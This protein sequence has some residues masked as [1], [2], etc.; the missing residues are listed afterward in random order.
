VFDCRSERIISNSPVKTGSVNSNIDA[1]NAN[2]QGNNGI[3]LRVKEGES[4]SQIV[5]QKLTDVRQEETPEINKPK[6]K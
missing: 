2:A 5:T 1:V 3:V 6:I 4:R